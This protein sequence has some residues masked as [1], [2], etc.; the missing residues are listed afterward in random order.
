[1]M[2]DVR[3]EISGSK[4]VATS[5]YHPDLPTQ[6]KKLGGKW[7]R[8]R[9]AWTFDPRDEQRARQLYREIY[10]TD[11]ENQDM[12]LV[13]LLVDM[14][15]VAPEDSELYLAGRLVASVR[16]R[17]SGATLGR[18]VIFDQG[19]LWSTG[20]TKYPRIG[21]KQGTRLLVRDVPAGIARETA[22]EWA[23]GISVVEDNAPLSW[24]EAAIIE[25]VSGDPVRIQEHDHA[26]SL[27]PGL[28]DKIAFAR[29]IW[30]AAR[31]Q[32]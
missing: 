10:G 12:P 19:E 20:S 4:L 11:G 26:L 15:K 24:D 29:A 31:S 22:S 1:M 8:S 25:F 23:D 7:D 3:I 16:G 13:D 18:G 27:E 9:K 2:M 28:A 32:R 30:D 5:P 21:W 14:D 17:D 6:A